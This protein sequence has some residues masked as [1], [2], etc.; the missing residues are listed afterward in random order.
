MGVGTLK[1]TSSD[2]THSKHGAAGVDDVARVAAVFDDARRP[3]NGT[4]AAFTLNPL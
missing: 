2:R 4:A 1:I 3:A